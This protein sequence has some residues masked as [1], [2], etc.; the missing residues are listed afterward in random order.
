MD[1]SPGARPT[2]SAPSEE[3]RDDEPRGS[4]DLTLAAGALVRVEEGTIHLGD[5]FATVRGLLG[6]GKRT[7]AVNTRSYE[8]SLRGGVELAVWFA[9]SNL[10]DDTPPVDV[11]DS[12]LVLW[13]SVRGA[14][15]GRTPEGIGMGSL[16]A[17]VEALSGYGAPPATVDVDGGTVA[18][19]FTNGLHLTYGADG[20]VVAVTVARA[21]PQAPDGIIDVEGAGLDFG[22]AGSIKGLRAS[23]VFSAGSPESVVREILGAPD[24]M[25]EVANGN[26]RFRVLSYGFLG[27]EL[28]FLGEQTS[29]AFV[30]IHAPYYGRARTDAR[31]GIGSTREALETGLG[32]GHGEP[33]S[34]SALS[35][36]PG[37]QN[38]RV[39]VTYGADGRSTSITMPLLRCP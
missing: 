22:T 15:P 1:A 26:Q 14:Y 12:D 5:S 21:Y 24:A 39:G 7:A 36:Y 28:F 4:G 6:A 11:D 27:I 9:N 37:R 32:L 31:I 38:P 3:A 30:T 16:R 18:Q 10:D 13:V 20:R 23:P 19:Y 29:V 33:S 17:E 34:S 35:C 25:G 2:P 8:W